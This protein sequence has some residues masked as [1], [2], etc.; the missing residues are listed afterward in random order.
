[1]GKVVYFFTTED[2]VDAADYVAATIGAA[3]RRARVRVGAGA[4]WPTWLGR[5]QVP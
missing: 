5:R 2:V 3:L 1:M 4:I